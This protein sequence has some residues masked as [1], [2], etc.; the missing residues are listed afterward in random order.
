MQLNRSSFFEEFNDFAG[1]ANSSDNLLSLKTLFRES[2]GR[3]FPADSIYIFFFNHSSEALELFYVPELPAIELSKMLSI[4]Q[5]VYKKEKKYSLTTKKIDE[6]QKQGDNSKFILRSIVLIPLKN[7]DKHNGVLVIAGTK[8]SRYSK[9]VLSAFSLLGNITYIAYTRVITADKKDELSLLYDRALMSV[10][11]GIIITDATKQGNPIIFVNSA[12]VRITGYSILESIGTNCGFLQGTDT[13]PKE[14][15]KLNDAIKA[16]IECA[17]V[18]RNYRKNG[19]SF[20]NELKISPI[21]NNEGITTHFIGVLNDI[22]LR[23]EFENKIKEATVRISALIQNLQSG[24][25]VEDESRRIVV[26][27]REFCNMF[28][29]PY[30]PDEL[31]G[32]DCNKMVDNSGDTLPEAKAFADRLT[33]ILKNRETVKGEEIYLPGGRVLE[34]DYIP[35]FILEDYCGHLWQYRDVTERFNFGK[36]IEKLKSF[37]EQILNDLPGQIAVFDTNLNYLFINPGSMQNAELRTWIIG[38][39]DIDYCIKRNIDIEIGRQR[40]QKLRN[41]INEKQAQAFEEIVVRDGQRQ[42]FT[43]V[44]SPVLDSSGEVKHL[45]GYGLN[46]TDLKNAEKKLSDSQRQLLAVLNTV[47]EGIVSFDQN[48]NIVMINDEIEKIWGYS[49]E[50]LVGESVQILF[51]RDDW[52]DRFNILINDVSIQEKSILGKRIESEGV[53][54]DGT[55]FPFAVKIQETRIDNELYFTG[56]ISDITEQKRAIENLIQAQKDAEKLMQAKQEFLAHMSHEIRT[57]LN[58]IIG[59]NNIL[60]ETALNKKEQKYLNAIKTSADN[61]LYIINDLLDFSKLDAGKIEFDSLGFSIAE[62]FQKALQIVKVKADE[63]RIMLRSKIDSLIPETLIGDPDRLGQ[64]LLNLLTN[65]VKFTN[66]GYINLQAKLIEKIER[67]VIVEFTVQD[68]GIGIKEEKLVSVFES[69]VQ[70]R[71]QNAVNPGGTGLGLAISKKLVEMQN[72]T[73]RVSSTFGTG[74]TF[75][76][77]LP[78]IVGDNVVKQALPK[79]PTTSLNKDISSIHI[80]VAEDNEL[81]IM[82]IENTLLLWN[83]KFMIAKNGKEVL[84]LLEENNFDIILMDIEMP[85]MDGFEATRN[86]RDNFQPPKRDIPIIALTASVLIPARNKVIESGMT[87]FL[88]KPFIPVELFNK[89]VLHTRL[90]KSAVPFIGRVDNL[91]GDEK[92]FSTDY[93]KENFG[94]DQQVLQEFLGKFLLHTEGYIFELLTLFLGNKMS[95]VAKLAHKIRPTFEYLGIQVISSVLKSIELDIKN[96]NIDDSIEPRIIEISELWKKLKIEIEEELYEK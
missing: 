81:N 73:I 19:E 27:N 6:L 20:W 89:I 37:Y 9:E 8:T 71:N 35:I 93:F 60:I 95:E 5:K 32:F 64:V 31:I 52:E 62:V 57:P 14:L 42:V 66:I 13:D 33:E 12:Y 24:I 30:S 76:L 82:V 87:D 79:E 75:A 51:P 59:L 34:R 18:L 58:A 22:T 40:Q 61:L 2:I 43:R 68:T 41:A 53:R 91:Q 25:L 80:L 70:I 17:V 94:D 44:I 38:K 90:S 55:R 88:S 11:N 4:A 28:S 23:I 46:I 3:L 54:N 39:N 7:C 49:K 83:A 29:I 21:I 84:S 92:L 72:G 26:T 47:G 56:A 96:N 63:K 69:F 15:K 78:F 67:N 45:L 74:S 77:C 86:I 16:K 1:K 36:E 85:V 65:A 50:Q 10:G 48:A